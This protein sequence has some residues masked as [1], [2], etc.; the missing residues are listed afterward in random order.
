MANIDL[1]Y[2]CILKYTDN[3]K[4]LYVIRLGKQ[5]KKI[6][7]KI[8]RVG[9]HVLVVIHKQTKEIIITNLEVAPDDVFRVYDNEEIFCNCSHRFSRSRCYLRECENDQ[10]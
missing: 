5:S 1:S 6:V 8:V 9:L 3:A 7:K 2:Y 10:C 4:G